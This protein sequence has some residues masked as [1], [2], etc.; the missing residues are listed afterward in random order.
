MHSARSACPSYKYM[1]TKKSRQ[2][3]LQPIYLNAHLPILN[4]KPYTCTSVLKTLAI[5]VSIKNKYTIRT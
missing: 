3:L 5:A 1:H 4:T 2:Q